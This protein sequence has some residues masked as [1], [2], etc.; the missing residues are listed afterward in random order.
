MSSE[1]ESKTTPLNDSSLELEDTMTSLIVTVWVQFSNLLHTI[2]LKL[3]FIIGG[4][5]TIL[6]RNKSLLAKPLVPF[7]LPALLPGPYEDKLS[8]S[9]QVWCGCFLVTS[10]CSSHTFN[11]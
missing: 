8:Q 9:H 6:N 5:V 7:N 1:T 11:I 4:E 2:I 3:Y 10:L